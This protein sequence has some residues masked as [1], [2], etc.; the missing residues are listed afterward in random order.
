MNIADTGLR[1]EPKTRLDFPP[2][3][4]WLRAALCMHM[5]RKAGGTPDDVCNI[6]GIG[7]DTFVAWCTN[8]QTEMH[9]V[10]GMINT[11]PKSRWAEIAEEAERKVSLQTKAARKKK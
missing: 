7:I 10:S 6:L 5:V 3:K 8:H 2:D 1:F 4:P 11:R 9:A